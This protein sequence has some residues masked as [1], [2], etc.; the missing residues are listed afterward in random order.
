MKSSTTGIAGGLILLAPLGGALGGLGAAQSGWLAFEQSQLVRPVIF[1]FLV[2]YV[3]T[4]HFIFY[5]YR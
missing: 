4:N 5:S 2:P 3:L 1:V